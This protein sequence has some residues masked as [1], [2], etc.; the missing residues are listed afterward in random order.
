MRGRYRIRGRSRSRLQY[1]DN[2]KLSL[3]SINPN[4]LK[5]V[6]GQ[7]LS[8]LKRIDICDSGEKMY[9]WGWVKIII[10]RI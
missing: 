1:S 7:S 4:S 10:A 8:S 6:L 3:R 2:M 5:G 9:L